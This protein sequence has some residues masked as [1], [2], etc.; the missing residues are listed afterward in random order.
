MLTGTEALPLFAHARREDPET[1][2]QAAKSIRRLTARHAAVWRVLA[3]I[4]DATHE[5]LIFCYDW[6]LDEP[7]WVPQSDASIRS[8]CTE[9]LAHGLVEYTGAK[10]PSGNGRHPMRVVRAIEPERAER[11]FAAVA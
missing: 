2:H 10:R 11:L 6:R 5:E 1:S 9:L 8:R 4:G 3:D 7:W